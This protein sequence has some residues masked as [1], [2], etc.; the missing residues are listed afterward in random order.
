MR[1]AILLLLI[2]AYVHA[3]L[4]FFPRTRP[5]A[6]QLFNYVLVPL[7]TIG[8]RVWG[9]IPDLVYLVIIVLITVYV[10]KATRLFFGAIEKGTITFKG[11]YPEWAQPTY[12]ICR[13]LIVAGVAIPPTVRIVPQKND[14][15]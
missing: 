9:E 7:K 1:F 8:G 12:K 14:A 15:S 10:L 2:Y 4:S 11:F 13:L 6:G 3:G 5:F